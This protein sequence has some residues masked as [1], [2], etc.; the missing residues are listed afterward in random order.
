MG[1]SIRPWVFA[2]RQPPPPFTLSDEVASAH[3][4][5]LADLLDPALRMPYP[6]VHEGVDLILPSIRTGGLTIWGLTYQMVELFR[7]VV[8]GGRP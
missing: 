3:W 1:L 6:Y 5:P 2:L 8:Y 7:T 4:V